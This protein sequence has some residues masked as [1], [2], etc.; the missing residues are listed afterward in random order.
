MDLV[1][2]GWGGRQPEYR[3]W[4]VSPVRPNSRFPLPTPSVA[5]Q[6][7]SLSKLAQSTFSFFFF[8]CV[9]RG[10]NST[11]FNGSRVEKAV[12]RYRLYSRWVVSHK[13]TRMMDYTVLLVPDN[14][15][16]VQWG[17]PADEDGRQA[18]QSE[19][20]TSKFPGRGGGVRRGRGVQ[21]SISRSGSVPVLQSWERVTGALQPSRATYVVPL[22]SRLH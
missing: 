14:S 10:P 6:N 9:L 20:E 4:K 3:N 5:S 18:S 15:E 11:Q 19:H 13:L 12:P 16:G 2:T 7:N 21:D 8:F 1:S 17:G 22:Q